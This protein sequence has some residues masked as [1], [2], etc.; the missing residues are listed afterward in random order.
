MRTAISPRCLAVVFATVITVSIPFST[1]TAQVPEGCP[2]GGVAYP[3]DYY[4]PALWGNWVIVSDER[5]NAEQLAATFADPADA[6]A[7][8]QAWCWFE[9]AE[10]VYFNTQNDLTVDVSIHDFLGTDGVGLAQRW[11]GDQRANNLGLH[12]DTKTSA[13]LEEDLQAAW[14]RPVDI[15]TLDN[16]VIDAYSNDTEYTLYARQG[17]GTGTQ[18]V[19]PLPPDLVVRVTASGEPSVGGMSREVLAYQVLAQ[20]FGVDPFRMTGKA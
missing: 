4:L 13:Q 9:Q 8:L 10:R 5:R 16:I 6:L 15:E 18:T 14:Q 19:N 17:T 12:R 7:R 20:I 1:V 2:G 11:F 3:V